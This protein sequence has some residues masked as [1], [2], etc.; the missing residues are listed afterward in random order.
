MPRVDE[1]A[2]G[3]LRPTRAGGLTSPNLADHTPTARCSHPPQLPTQDDHAQA[4][5]RGQA[6]TPALTWSNP[7]STD[8]AG[9]DL[10]QFVGGS[11]LS[12]GSPVPTGRACR[13]IQA[14]VPRGRRPIAMLK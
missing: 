14:R 10:L 4:E 9:N 8:Q 3:H 12:H 11:R 7:A 5:A 6:T 13:Q 2:R 1:P